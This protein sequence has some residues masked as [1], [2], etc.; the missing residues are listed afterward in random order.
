[1]FATAGA[2]SANHL[3]KYWATGHC[4]KRCSLDPHLNCD[5]KRTLD[6]KS[7]D[8]VTRSTLLLS[9]EVTPFG[10]LSQL[11]DSQFQPAFA[12]QSMRAPTWAKQSRRLWGALLSRGLESE[13]RQST[14]DPKSG[15][16][17]CQL[18]RSDR[19]RLLH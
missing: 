19:W 5:N 7:P 3:S 18:C 16:E 6:A 8:H 15:F 4:A 2:T 12:E 17:V 1:P 10:L 14:G 11:I 9:P 13:Y